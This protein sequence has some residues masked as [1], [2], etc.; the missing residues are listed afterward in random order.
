[1]KPTAL[2]LVCFQNEHFPDG[3]L[4]LP[5]AEEAA[6]RAGVLLQ[7]FR[8]HHQLHIH[9]QRE[10]RQGTASQFKPGTEGIRINDQVPHYEGEPIVYP[11]REN[12]FSDPTLISILTSR[13]IGRLIICGLGAQALAQ[14]SLE[15]RT[16]GLEVLL[17]HDAIAGFPFP[18]IEELGFPVQSVEATIALLAGEQMPGLRNFQTPNKKRKRH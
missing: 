15:A 11:T 16:L 14:T 6:R 5:G 2:L 18:E 4:P 17:C 8:D 13:S 10:D 12:A 3:K 1:M 7:C 9:A